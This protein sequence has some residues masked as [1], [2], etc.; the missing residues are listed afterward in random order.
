MTRQIM[1]PVT[2]A[3]PTIIIAIKWNRNYSQLH[4]IAPE[5]RQADR[6]AW[7]MA[8]SALTC[9][10]NVIY[11]LVKYGIHLFLSKDASIHPPIIL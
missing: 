3:C 2:G 11:L 7:A 1:A 9:Y 8:D 4:M 6:R 5:M 10:I